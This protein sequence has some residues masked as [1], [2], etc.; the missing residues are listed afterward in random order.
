M[1]QLNIHRLNMNS[2]NC[3]P[4]NVVG[5][6]SSGGGGGGGHI[7]DGHEYVN[8]GLPSGN[9]WAT[10]NV[11]A[12]E[13]NV[14]GSYYAWGEIAT[15]SNYAKSTYKHGVSPNVKKYCYNASAGVVDN[16]YVL[17]AEDDVVKQSWGGRW[18]MPT[19]DD[20][21]ELIDV[22]TIERIDVGGEGMFKVT[23]PNGRSALFPAGGVF[24]GTTRRDTYNY[25]DY[26]I[27]TLS[28]NVDTC[29]D[30]NQ[31]QFSATQEQITRV[32][33]AGRYLGLLVRPVISKGSKEFTLDDSVLDGD[34]WLG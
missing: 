19:E 17:D 1:K 2:L 10:M 25:G 29:A 24:D 26:W 4:L 21:Q 8:L 33:N 31:M 32:Q 7:I 16:K 3:V 6:V 34:D 28:R 11:G 9:L 14:R 18:G 12:D 20:Y 13:G 22:C 30:A 5:A 27:K 23:G 15:K